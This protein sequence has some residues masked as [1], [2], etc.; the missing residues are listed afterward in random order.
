MNKEVV[1]SVKTVLFTF[2]LI[3]AGYVIYRL[4]P[5]LGILLMALLIV[6]ALEPLVKHLM[7][8]TLFNKHVSRSLAVVVSYVVFIIIVAVVL[9][10]GLPPFLTQ[11]QTLLNSL[12]DIMHKLNLSSEFKSMTIT[13]FIPQAANISGG[14]INVILSL[15]SNITTVFS[16]L[17]LSIYMSLDWENIKKMFVGL[18]PAKIGETVKDTVEEIEQSIGQWVKGEAIL[19]LVIGTF[20]FGGLL[21]L[22][23]NYPLALGL[24][25][26]AFEVVPMIGPIMSAVLAGVIGFADAPIKGIGVIVLF[27]II[28]QLENNI[29]VPKVMQKVSGFSPIVILIA[30]LVGSEF[31]GIIGAITA[32]PM[33]MVLTII[34]KRILR[35]SN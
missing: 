27:T 8:Q 1:I 28:Q 33:T 30:L 17:I 20:S 19:M 7:K 22:G 18:F 14:V 2:A 9:G 21:I 34:L 16:L 24:V 4:G 32:V 5:V 25:A 11:A 6:F 13:D 15:F 23:V 26:G 31:F 3:L 12:S 35:Y 29:L 10:V